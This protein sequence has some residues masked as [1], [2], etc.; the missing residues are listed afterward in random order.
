M[1]AFAVLVVLIGLMQPT[2]TIAGQAVAG[3][4]GAWGSGSSGLVRGPNNIWRPYGPAAFPPTYFY[5]AATNGWY[6]FDPDSRQWL[7]YPN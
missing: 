4:S 7:W 6:V 1:R 3:S 2:A 5:D